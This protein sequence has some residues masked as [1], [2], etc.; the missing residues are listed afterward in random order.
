M[1]GSASPIRFLQT[2]AELFPAK[3]AI[4]CGENRFTYK[5]YYDRANRLAYALLQIGVRRGDRVS[6]LGYNSH[7]LLEAYYGVIQAGAV[8]M[9]LNIRLREKDFTFILNHAA[10]DTI[11]VHKDFIP[12]INSIKHK[13]ANMKK[14][15]AISSDGADGYIDY[16][17][18]L[19]SA[20]ADY[21]IDPI[22][23]ENDLA[24][25]FYTSGT[26]GKPKGV[27]LSHRNLYANALN[28]LLSLD[29]KASDVLLHTI[30]LF[31][32]N[33]W[34]TPHALTYV[35][36]THVMIPKF[37]AQKVCDLIEKENVTICCMV[38]TMASALLNHP[39]IG[40]HDMS[41]IKK[42][43]VGGAFS[44]VSLVKQ[45]E[46]KIGCTYIASY[47]LTEASPV[48]A[49]AVLKDNLRA[50]PPEVR[51]NYQSKAGL[52]VIGVETRIIDDSGKDINHDGHGTGELIL[53]GDTVMMGYWQDPEGTEQVI[54]DGWLHTGDMA[55]IDHEG[56]IQIVDRKKDIIISGGENI[57]TLEIENTLHAH[58][59]VLEAAVVGFT[60]ERWGEI[61]K[62]FIVLKPLVLTIDAQDIMDFCRSQLAGFKVPRKV[63]FVSS[64]P[65]SGT[66]KIMKSLLKNR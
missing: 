55:T 29:L 10:A 38:P 53:R 11:L 33:G 57:S 46:S 49:N 41:S 7:T 59:A 31:H 58:P 36:G 37:E 14:Y 43:V 1:H 12:V 62:A 15:I 48:V 28:F 32:V 61:P 39:G 18:L 27:M 3:T 45:I 64:L 42:L 4:V 66:G 24:E 52:P 54:I 65:K 25:L 34:G 60:D 56:Y 40:S 23:S 13:L 2:A 26:T 30:P 8:L 16:E 17:D 44:P 22:M 6:Y 5:E 50:M 47:G 35:G 51:Y 9:P 20:P 63:E 21:Y 19:E